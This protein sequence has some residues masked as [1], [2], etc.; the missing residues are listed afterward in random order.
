VASSAQVCMW[1][2]MQEKLPTRG[3]LVRRGVSVPSNLCPLCS[4]VEETSEH[5]LI[6]CE[7]AQKVWDNCDR[8]IGM[9]FIC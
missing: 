5:V 4:K 7:V 9:Y 1:R 8:W 2:A 3:N 6:N